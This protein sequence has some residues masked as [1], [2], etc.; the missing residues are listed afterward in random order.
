M[1]L[2]TK[3]A[4]G[5]AAPAPG[6]ETPK[7]ITEE[8]LEKTLASRFKSVEQRVEKTIAQ[9]FETFSGKLKTDLESIFPKPEPKPESKKDHA[10]NPE[11]KKLEDRIASLTQ[12]AETARAERD[13]ERVKARDATLRQKLG[14]R[15]ATSG[16]DGVRA[17]HAVGVLVDSERRVRWSEDGETILFRTPDGDELDLE[18]GVRAWLKTDDA[19]LYL[20]PRGSQGSGDRPGSGSPPSAASGPLDRRTVAEGLRRALLGQF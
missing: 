9:T 1:D 4:D 13:T 6:A 11:L 2:E 17:R 5:T 14:E 7:Y 16:I 18:P 8:H 12:Q 3:P 10:E 20:P 15:L 19:K